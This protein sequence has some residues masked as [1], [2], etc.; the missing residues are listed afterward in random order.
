MLRRTPSQADHTRNERTLAVVLALGLLFAGACSTA[1]AHTP[2]ATS[3][4]PAV[5]ASNGVGTS[6]SCRPALTPGQHT[7]SIVVGARTRV[8]IVHV[9]AVSAL[10]RALP[11]VVDMHGS[12]ST[13]VQ[14]EVLS[15][16]NGTADADGFV[17]VYPQAIIRSGAGFLWNIPGVP[18]IGGRRAPAR[19]AD[20]IAFIRAVVAK[21]R[22]SACID[23]TRVYATGFS[24]GA[25]LS[26]QLACDAPTVVAAVA[27]VS[28]L[29]LPSPCPAT[30]AVPVIAFHGSADPVDPYAGNGQAY[31]TYSVPV[32]VQR[33]SAH[34]GC[35]AS[36]K[37]S[38]P[39]SGATLATYTGCRDGAT[40][41]LY[42]LNGEGHEWPGGPALP[43]TVTRLLG[44]QTNAV[45]AND[46][47]WAFF[48]A[49]PMP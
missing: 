11:L 9:P 27:P 49:H 31:W 35:S 4:G 46:L 36:P 10:G 38:Q 17:V 40:V 48:A 23:L 39:A 1:H 45:N 20:D 7:V 6:A 32:A 30:R 44:P 21:L 18:L 16:M 34:D 29:R 2:E 47:M 13:A 3:S 15:D 26:S 43:R 37:T 5:Q 19:A 14:Q 41:E 22:S 8:M 28:G 33:W 42:T 24:G 12:G 25:R